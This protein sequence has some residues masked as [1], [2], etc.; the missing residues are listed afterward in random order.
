MASSASLRVVRPFGLRFLPLR[1]WCYFQS[2]NARVKVPLYWAA[3]GGH[4][5][6][7]SILLNH[8]D[9]YGLY[10]TIADEE[11][12]IGRTEERGTSLSETIDILDHRSSVSWRHWCHCIVLFRPFVIQNKSNKTSLNMLLPGPCL[13]YVLHVPPSTQPR[14][15]QWTI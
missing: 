12:G 8:E 14:C 5:K 11:V 10:S 9:E 1:L 3:G 6:V 13:V 15:V 4:V 2:P 7:A